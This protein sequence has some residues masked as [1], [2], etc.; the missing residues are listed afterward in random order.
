MLERLHYSMLPPVSMGGI[1]TPRTRRSVALGCDGQDKVISRV[2]ASFMP[3][4]N[5]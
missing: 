4:I 5:S 1:C 3:V 2:I